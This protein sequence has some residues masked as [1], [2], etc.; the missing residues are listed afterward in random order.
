MNK[1]STKL[2]VAIGIGA[3]LYGILG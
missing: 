1:L 2:V 3:A